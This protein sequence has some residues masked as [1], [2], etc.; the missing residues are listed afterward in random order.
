[1]SK[2]TTRRQRSAAYF[3]EALSFATANGMA[4]P[5]LIRALSSRRRSWRAE[6]LRGNKAR[7]YRTASSTLPLSRLFLDLPLERPS[8]ATEPT[9]AGPTTQGPEGTRGWEGGTS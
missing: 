3:R 7:T 6:F 5:D 8:D 4:L 9:S 1:M 2:T